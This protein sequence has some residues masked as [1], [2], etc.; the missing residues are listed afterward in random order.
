MITL[1]KRK[2]H[3][4][5]SDKKFSEI[6]TGSVW[7]LGSRIFSTML[8]MIT[9]II[10]AR[11]YGVEAMGIVAMVN[12]F[13]TLT[14]I[15][16]V[17]GTGSSILRLIPEH[18]TKYS[19]TSAFKTYRKTQLLIVSISGITGGLLFFGSSLIA[20]KI[21]S[22]PHLSFLFALAAGFV[23]FK[24]LMILNTQA[25]RGLRLMRTFAFMQ[26]LPSLSNLLILIVLTFL[27]FNQFNPIYAFFA[28]LAVTASFGIL[29]M[30]RKF[31]KIIVKS[32]IIQ[33]MPIKEVLS[34]SL[35]MLMTSTMTFV[36]GQTGVVLLGMFRSET[37]VGYYAIAVKLATLTAFILQ[38]I[39][40]IAAPKFS[41]LNHSGKM[42]EL[43]HVA[44]KSSKL[45]FWTT[46]PILITLLSFGNF[47]LVLLYGPNFTV[48][49][50]ALV[51]LVIGQFVNAISGSTDIFMNMTGHQNI[52]KNIMLISALLNIGLNLLLIP[53][54]GI[55]GSAIAATITT[56]FWNSTT[57]FYIKKK[58]GKVVGYLPLLSRCPHCLSTGETKLDKGDGGSANAE[59][60]SE[61]N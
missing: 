52:F 49:Y 40:T 37:E 33:V 4:L 46:A 39:N 35:P 43:F 22:K 53:T 44:K 7:A 3:N 32:D 61:I 36:I 60:I 42:D 11:V 34:I 59:K 25:V 16:T 10:I 1:C 8:A 26:L 9:S 27:L 47:F 15:F 50:M 45:I 2:L 28:S 24:S 12:S 56:C 23:V 54:F 13:L 14:T 57:L 30:D 58:Y 18:I 20:S 51:Y 29:I 6:L 55:V 38:A 17:L 5:I 48:A 21:F 31:K 41:Q 19:A